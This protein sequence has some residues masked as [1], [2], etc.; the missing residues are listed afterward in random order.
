MQGAVTS[1][2]LHEAHARGDPLGTPAWAG[3]AAA[4]VA[5]GIT[6]VAL[7]L[8]AATLTQSPI[9]IAGLAVGHS[10]TRSRGSPDW[11]RTSA[12]L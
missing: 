3:N 5:D 12:R 1:N 7:P 6:F 11:P 2:S 4:N 8:L 9:A 10:K